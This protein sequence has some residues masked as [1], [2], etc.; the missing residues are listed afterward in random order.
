MKKI[1]L[2]LLALTTVSQMEMLAIPPVGS[3]AFI[4][5]T[6]DDGLPSNNVF[7]LCR[8]KNGYLWMG[9]SAGLARYDGTRIR[10][11]Y[12]EELAVRDNMVSLLLYDS[13]DRLWIG[14]G[15]GVSVYN[16]ESDE[17]ASL[18][19]LCGI[20]VE[21]AVAWMFE[22]RNGMVWISFKGD[23]L[24]SIDPTVWKATR[25]FYHAGKE[26]TPS[27]IS[28]ILMDPE[29][30][31]TLLALNDKGLY[32]ADLSTETLTPFRLSQYPGVDLFSG[33]LVKTLLPLSDSTLLIVTEDR[34][35]YKINPYTHDG[36]QV[37]LDFGSENVNL[38]RSYRV[39]DK[40]IAILSTRGFYL[41]DMENGTLTQ[42]QYMYQDDRSISGRSIHCLAGNLKDGLILGFHKRGAAIQMQHGARFRK[43]SRSEDTPAVPLN[44]SEVT[45]FA[46]Q[47]DSTVWMGTRQKGL[48][49][50]NPLRETVHKARVKGIPDEIL[51]VA[52]CGGRLWIASGKAVC[53]FDPASGAVKHYLSGYQVGNI[54][55]SG[56]ALLAVTSEG[57]FQ[58][59]A[60][61]DVFVPLRE[62]RGMTVTALAPS[63]SG[64][65]WVGFREKG[66]YAW[67]GTVLKKPSWTEIPG[68][69]GTSWPKSIYEAPDRTLWVG[70][71]QG[72]VA[73]FSPRS[74]HRINRVSGL[75]SNDVSSVIGDVAGNIWIATDR[76]LA[77]LP[78]SGRMIN[79]TRSSGLLNFG[80]SSDAVLRCADGT[81][82]LGSKDGF[83]VIIPGT[84]PE[85]GGPVKVEFGPAEIGREWKLPHDGK[86]VI[87]YTRNTFDITVSET[88]EGGLGF[89]KIMYSLDGY[90]NTWTPLGPEGRI[91]FRMVPSGWYRLC[92]LGADAGDSLSI[93][94]RPPFW[95]SVWAILLYILSAGGVIFL[96]IR[97]IL[98]SEKRKRERSINQERLKLFTDIAREIR[99]PLNQISVPL[100]RLQNKDG[101]DEKTRYDLAQIDKNAGYL[102]DLVGNLLSNRD[103]LQDDTKG[104]PARDLTLL[105]KIRETVNR[106]LSN[107]YFGVDQLAEELNISRSTLNRKMNELLMTTAG[108][109]IR[110]RRLEAAEHLLRTTSLQ[111]NEIC[112]RVG[113]T[114]NSTFIKSFKARYGQSPARY[115]HSV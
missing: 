27:F 6:V 20:S 98:S 81:V 104:L 114:S 48:F 103:K 62:W 9:T 55:S 30:G 41:Y 74:W 90:D 78:P 23:G 18:E 105:Q 113:F 17:F 83:S 39:S 109:Y 46:Q 57:A 28:R 102:G 82:L 91:S 21:T 77:M 94:I 89:G 87:P 43:V 59:N 29:T 86:L 97:L 15:N 35:M 14:T 40:D 4:R 52:A 64:G 76:E 53:S 110:D 111:V 49:V 1:L 26:T 70:R 5:L 84:E 25:Y 24:F 80:F 36:V 7:D 50:Y 33:T 54:R 115:A 10:N 51:S 101:L 65:F 107:P 38:R 58:Y 73:V 95:R 75:Y 3:S 96:L 106:E 22:S 85:G 108:N 11:Y 16:S 37:P 19:S 79:F 31:L 32:Y 99:T 34:R 47:D 63:S 66:I 72:G 71:H 93:R 60:D 69:D 67:N 45:S 88:S 12:K 8:D 61:A 68:E 42:S 13:H 56:E 92:F 44:G 100:R 112:T 2:I